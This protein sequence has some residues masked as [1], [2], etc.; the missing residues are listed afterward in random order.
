M[1]NNIGLIYKCTCLINS[2]VYIGQTTQS[3]QLRKQQHLYSAK[4]S[5]Y[6][7]YRAIQKYGSDN[8]EWCVID[9]AKSLIEL[10]EKEDYY[11]SIFNSIKNGYNSVLNTNNTTFKERNKKL[12]ISVDSIS[13]MLWFIKNTDLTN[14][15]VGKLFGYSTTMVSN[16][17]T[18]KKNMRIKSSIIVPYS[19]ILK[20]EEIKIDT[21]KHEY[22]FK[23][24]ISVAKKILKE[25][26]L[27]Q[28]QCAKVGLSQPLI[29]LLYLNKSHTEIEPINTIPSQYMSAIN[30]INNNENIKRDKIIKTILSKK[31]L[32]MKQC[33]DMFK[34][35]KSGVS[36]INNKVDIDIL[37]VLPKDILER[38]DEINYN[39][40][41]N[42]KHVEQN[43]SYIK[44][45]LDRKM[46]TFKECC[47]VFNVGESTVNK[48]A[49]NTYYKEIEE[50]EFLP[51]DI[52][53]KINELKIKKE[54]K[55]NCDKLNSKFAIKASII[56]KLINDGIKK[57]EIAKIV[58]CSLSFVKTVA[59]G[60]KFKEIEPI[61]EFTI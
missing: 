35:S 24:K 1:E 34:I 61:K 56:K 23:Y 12:Q 53:N 43:I 37:D 27:N 14:Y 13:N 19:L 51:N 50:I 33:S 3:L 31:L 25:N 44:F 2:K 18:N 41:D 10:N 26:L 59:C 20:S 42:K 32:N 60:S 55:I 11:I 9:Y 48:I 52:M 16:Y 29:S 8:F 22:E 39:Y 57:S 28:S 45:V 7:F 4:R 21:R 46:L 17:K 6:K 40:K 30:D 58:N 47:E 54:E 38:I 5:D 15:E 36:Y 49:T